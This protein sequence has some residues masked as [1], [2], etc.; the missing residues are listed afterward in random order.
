[1]GY[2]GRGD[3]S[4]KR[5]VS[6][7]HGVFHAAARGGTDTAVLRRR[8]LEGGT[9]NGVGD[10]NGVGGRSAHPAVLRSVAMT[11]GRS[12]PLCQGR[13]ET[14]GSVAGGWIRHLPF[15]LGADDCCARSTRHPVTLQIINVLQPHRR[16]SATTRGVV[17]SFPLGGYG[18][19]AADPPGPFPAR[20]ANCWADPSRRS[21]PPAAS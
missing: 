7:A 16:N 3:L 20:H 15:P 6:A 8:L 13:S 10:S 1:M 4:G 14:I 19:P 21:S 2:M 5:Q 12:S 9:T 18:L 11:P 17:T